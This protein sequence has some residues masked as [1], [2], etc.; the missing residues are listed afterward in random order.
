[1]T[2]SQ[3]RA[4]VTLVTRPSYLAGVIILAWSLFKSG[5]QNPLLVLTTSTLGEKAT[6]ILEREATKNPLLI[7]KQ[8]E[9][10]TPRELN[11]GS[12]AARFQDTYTKLRAFQLHELG[13][14]KCVFLDADMAVF[15]NP[16]EL[17]DVALPGKD[18]IAANHACVCNLDFDSF[19]PE[20]WNK[21]NCAYTP[22]D[23]PDEPPTEVTA[24]A[25]PT[26]HLLNSGMFVYEPSKAIWDAMMHEFDTSPKIKQYAFP[27]QDFLTDFYR[28]KWM[29]LSWRYN[30]LKTMRTWHP[31]MYKDDKVVVLHYIVDKP[32]DK[33]MASDGIGGH[34][35]RDGYTHQ[36]WWDFYEE[37]YAK[38]KSAEEEAVRNMA[39]EVEGSLPRR[40]TAEMDKDQVEKNKIFEDPKSGDRVAV[41]PFGTPPGE[42]SDVKP[43]P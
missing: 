31:R 35:G 24:D 25:R 20:D 7:V 28:N 4:Y 1:M 22:I 34:L 40:L 27:D 9:P 2:S 11:T 17:F 38:R 8:V 33:R 21:G 5:A 32:W 37:W 29:S 15:K 36:Q 30:A 23:G 6:S 41:K 43:W 13:Y 42:L 3:P 12:A 26:Y 39:E 18:W 16:D 10:L 19:A 14:E